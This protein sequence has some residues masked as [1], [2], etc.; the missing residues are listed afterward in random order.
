MRLQ[1][2]PM[3][4]FAH[5]IRG[6]VLTSKLG[7]L[8]L[9]FQR[10]P[11]VQMLLPEAKVLGGAGLGEVTK[12]A[13]TT[14]AGLGAYDTVAGATSIEQVFP[15]AGETIVPATTGQQLN[16]V[17]QVVNT[18][19]VAN[20]SWSVSG[21]PAGLTHS[22]LSDPSTHLISG[23]PVEDG[24]TTVT[25]TAWEMQNQT[26]ASF[27][28]EFLIEVAPPI[29]ATHPA[30]VAI[31]NGTQATLS[32]VGNPNG[33]TLTYRWFRGTS[34]SGT[35]V[36]GAAG[37]G[38]NF[39]TQ[40]HSTA[41]TPENYWV[42]VTRNGVDANSNTATVSIATAPSIT[43][44]PVPTT[45]PSGTTANLSVAVSGTSPAI[46]WYRGA[47]GVT[48]DPVAGATS[49][50]FT[51]PVLTTTTSYWARA[52][53]SAGTA[54]SNAATV[55]VTADPF[56]EWKASQF[57]TAQLAD[58]QVSGATA[59]PDGDGIANQDEYV[60]GTLALTRE[61]SPLTLTLDGNGNVSLG[62]TARQASGAGYRGKTRHYAL[63]TRS[64]LTSGTWTP[65]A[66]F[67]DVVGNNQ[68]VTYSAPAAPP[69]AFY[70][71]RVWL[72]P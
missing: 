9:L 53:N 52:S 71:L 49:T 42:R 19:S 13:V 47:S 21:L 63:E 44:Q 46:Q 59:D 68:P 48:T 3:K 58:P 22:D 31:A 70:T 39:T 38:P 24:S 56:Q 4:H 45:I 26:G 23:T 25:V 8:V 66:G 1:L 41:N 36:S 28:Q 12:W 61:P 11:L 72:T 69:R 20:V 51:T 10:S 67:A 6:R 43:T 37:A 50:T 30:S 18:P 54:N 57:N 29:I 40:V 15:D 5:A 32:V 17:F 16:F 2:I 64:E 14:I 27:S 34:G 60:F 35:Q 55:T 7:S 62:F 65:L 33:Q